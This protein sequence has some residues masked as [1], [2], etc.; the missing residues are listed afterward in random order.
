MLI[1]KGAL[2]SYAL[3]GH[4]SASSTRRVCHIPHDVHALTVKAAA[5]DAL[6]NHTGAKEYYDKANA[7]KSAAGS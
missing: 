3:L 7:I 6:G 4:I 1:T 5:L 2:L